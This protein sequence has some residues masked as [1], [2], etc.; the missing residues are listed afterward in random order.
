M[1]ATGFDK[2]L[3][4]DHFLAEDEAV[5]EIFYRTMDPAICIYECPVRA[6]RECQNLP[7]RTDLIDISFEHDRRERAPV[8]VTPQALWK[9]LQDSNG[10]EA[11]TIVDVREPREYKQAHIPQARLLPLSSILSDEV[12]LPD[13]RRIVLVC[14]SG[15]RSQRA[16][17]VLR[18]KGFKHLAVLEG[19]MLAWES[20]DL[21]QAVG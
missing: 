5:G 7:K 19:G 4:Y 3:G 17:L 18:R 11:L 21:L 12:Q 15:R 8:K 9:Q 2:N 20:A 14:R 16:A 13:D 6:F 1:Q 10:H